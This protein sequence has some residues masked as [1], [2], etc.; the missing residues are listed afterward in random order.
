MSK[1]PPAKLIRKKK[2]YGKWK[3]GQA[4]WEEYRN[5]VRARR[6]STRK[7]QVHLKLNLARDVKDNKKGFFK[8]IGSKRIMWA[9]C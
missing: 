8:Y 1:E 7:A 5:V 9:H 6:E 4:T 3:E 2:V